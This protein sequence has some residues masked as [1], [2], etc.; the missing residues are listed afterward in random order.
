MN[1]IKLNK[2]IDTV[3]SRKLSIQI[4]IEVDIRVA[5]HAAAALPS[6]TVFP[7]EVCTAERDQ[8]GTALTA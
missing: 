5:L 7:S 3:N 8:I 1:W 4:C 2:Y 6:P